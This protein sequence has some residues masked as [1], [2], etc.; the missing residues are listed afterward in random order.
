MH[1]VLLNLNPIKSSSISFLINKQF[2][3]IIQHLKYN[4]NIT[5]TGIHNVICKHHKGLDHN[6]TMEIGLIFQ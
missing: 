2:Y 5:P 6:F 3:S 1:N 4:H